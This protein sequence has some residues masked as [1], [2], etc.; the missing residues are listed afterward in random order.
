MPTNSL[1]LLPSKIEAK[2]KKKKKLKLKNRVELNLPPL[3]CVV[4]LMTH[5]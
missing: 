3:E 1:T 5:W 4:N 2:K